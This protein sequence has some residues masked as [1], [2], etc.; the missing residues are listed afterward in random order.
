M[1][2][3]YGAKQGQSAGQPSRAL[4]LRLLLL[5]LPDN[6]FQVSLQLIRMSLLQLAAALTRAAAAAAAAVLSLLLMTGTT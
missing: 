1:R 4:L 2:V 3:V 6:L 5:E